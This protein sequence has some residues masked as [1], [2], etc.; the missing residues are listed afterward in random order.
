MARSPRP[1]I[2]GGLYHVAT[3][4]N[5]RQRIFFERR[6]GE[7]F[8][9]T[10]GDVIAVHR[11]RCHSYCLMP[12]HYHLLV[13]TPDP[14]IALGMH[15]LNSRFAHWFNARH[16]VTGHLFERR[17]RSV[18]VETDE[19]LLELVRYIALNPVRALLCDRAEMWE[20]SSYGALAGVR[21][22]DHLLSTRRIMDAFANTP[23]LAQTR[24]RTFVDDGR[25]KDMFAT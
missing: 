19:Y 16:E 7:V 8:L 24:L 18:V 5:R 3:R 20:W 17:Y 14:D 2:A 1:Q 4:G 13:E 10:L 21:E 22:P 6:D 23:E 15:R 9:S 11:W 12:N 25:P